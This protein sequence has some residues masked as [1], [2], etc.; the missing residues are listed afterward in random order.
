MYLLG[1]C[2]C[3]SGVV[4][5]DA[6]MVDDIKTDNGI[7]RSLPTP[8]SDEKDQKSDIKQRNI[9]VVFVDS[10]DKIF[11]TNVSTREME[12]CRIDQLKNRVKSFLNSDREESPMLPELNVAQDTVI[13]NCL[14]DC[15]VSK[16]IISL[17]AHRYTSY[18]MY[19]QVQDELTAAINELRNELSWNKF[20][21]A[22]HKDLPP[23]KRIS[24]EKAIPMAISEQKPSNQ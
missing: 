2:A 3:T 10:K 13:T 6:L 18:E 11:T 4:E 7:A 8:I 14:G 17:Q 16:G 9:F 15:K 21:C 22:N 19:F 24:V 5:D 12:P 1:V 20:G 23:E